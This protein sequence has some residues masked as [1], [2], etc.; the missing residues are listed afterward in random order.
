VSH[1]DRAR[2]AIRSLNYHGANLELAEY[3]L[4]C[5]RDDAPPRMQT[6]W[7]REPIHLKPT[8][9]FCRTRQGSE[10][11]CLWA[12]PMIRLALG[13]SISGHD[14]LQL[15]PA[16]GR[17]A[18]LQNAW[19]IVEGSVSVLYRDFTSV[20]GV[21]RATQGIALPFSD[22]DDDSTGYF[23]MHTNW[24]PVGDDWILGNVQV[25]LKTPYGRKTVSF[26]GT[27]S[28]RLQEETQPG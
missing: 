1:I 8:T 28:D 13:F 3:W 9:M 12:G 6:F 22:R 20:N 23:L 17:E 19:K 24:K 2:A 5:W 16:A 21:N 26:T 18:Q 11:H 14:L 4:S 10:L 27:H 7:E 25:D 15:I